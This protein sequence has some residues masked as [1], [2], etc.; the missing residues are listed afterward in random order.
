[1]S[2]PCSHERDVLDL[3]AVGQWPQRADTSLRA[4]VESCESC[5]EVAAIAAAVREWGDA[6]LVVRVPEASV[7]WHRAQVRARVTA[8]RAAS[9][10]V[11]MAQ[12]AALLVFL[13]GMVWIGP[14]SAWYLML[15]QSLTAAVPDVT[16]SAPT[17]SAWPGSLGLSTFTTGWGRAAL[18]VAGTVVLLASAA[19]GAV[20]ISE[21][22]EMSS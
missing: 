4:H 2:A 12:G 16:V 3:V 13:A 7:V 8:T 21:R 11:W 18:I 22:S 6:D 1:M 15:W 14:G 10:P 9:W 5:T 20:R 19:I 17:W